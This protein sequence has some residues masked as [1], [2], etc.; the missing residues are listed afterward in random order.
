VTPLAPAARSA[1]EEAMPYLMML[2]LLTLLTFLVTCAAM[3]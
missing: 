2:G 3:V 1:T